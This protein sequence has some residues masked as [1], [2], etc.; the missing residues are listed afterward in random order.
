MRQDERQAMRDEIRKWEREIAANPRGSLV[1]AMR[2]RIEWLR[3]R[4]ADDVDDIDD[5]RD[6]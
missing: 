5:V 6:L 3:K 4:L 2:H 1:P